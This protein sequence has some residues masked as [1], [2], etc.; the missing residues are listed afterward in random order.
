MLFLTLKNILMICGTALTVYMVY[1]GVI[2]LLGLVRKAPSF[3][4]A[5]PKKRF[6][7]VVAARNEAAVIGQLVDSLKAQDYPDALYE[8]IVAPNNC[9]DDTQAVA[10]AHG[11][12]IFQPQGT[13]RS[14]GEVLTQVV[15]EIV[16]QENFDAMCVFDAD[17]LASRQFLAR[18]NSALC[19][20]AQVVQGFRDSKNPEQSA[21]S[22]C[23]SICYWMLNRFYNSARSALGLSALVN[24]SGFTATA[25]LLRELGGWNTVTMTEDY[26]FSAQCA[27]TGHRVAFQPE[28]VIYD[29]QPLT[30]RQS[31]RQR[32]RWTTGSLQGLQVYGG[33]LFRETVLR[34]SAVCFDMTMTFLTPFVQ[35]ASTV[36]GITGAALVLAG[37]GLAFGGILLS[38]LRAAALMLGIGAA[39]TVLG[40]SLAAALTVVLKKGSLRGVMKGVATF[41]LFALSHM[42]LTLLSF[43][44][45]ERTWRPIAHTNT[46]RIEDLTA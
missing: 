9:T 20:G 33:R 40:T 1:F 21:I 12:R 2:A 34:R 14:K 43:V 6:A 31:W 44:K 39:G 18:M 22:G 15:D 29:E 13:I 26:E 10:R 42:A 17:N 11:A 5:Q 46:A 35:L 36:L 32:R 25:G 30:F 41:W 28:A 4:P 45:K 27:L 23:Y 7:C 19:G 38:G 37:H 8:V 24:G 3:T 16:L